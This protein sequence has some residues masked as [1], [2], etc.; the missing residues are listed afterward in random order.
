MLRGKPLWFNSMGQRVQLGV[1]LKFC[2]NFIVTSSYDQRNFGKF[3]KNS[4]KTDVAL[5]HGFGKVPGSRN[6]KKTAKEVPREERRK[7]NL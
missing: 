5:E 6:H 7:E 3:L 1:V 4:F 2:R